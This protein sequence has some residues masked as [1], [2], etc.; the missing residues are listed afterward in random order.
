MPAPSTPLPTTYM[1]LRIELLGRGGGRVGP[2]H[3]V[4]AG[5]VTVTVGCV[6]AVGAGGP[7]Q[8]GSKGCQQ[9]V[10]G[11]G[12]DGVVVEGDV[13]G[14]DADGKADPCESRSVKVQ[15]CTTLNFL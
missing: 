6:P 13:E 15:L 1:H 5:H 11:P 14:Y 10:Q 9:V 3:I 8:G 12:H 7:G 2:R 4:V